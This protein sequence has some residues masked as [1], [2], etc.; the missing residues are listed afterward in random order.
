MF[1]DAKQHTDNVRDNKVKD[2]FFM[3]EFDIVTKGLI[4]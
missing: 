2:S 4:L 1:S 3:I